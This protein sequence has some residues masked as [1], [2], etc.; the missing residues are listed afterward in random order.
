MPLADSEKRVDVVFHHYLLFHEFKCC[1]KNADCYNKNNNTN[2]TCESLCNTYFSVCFK[3]N[4]I[5]S[6][7]CYK[8]T[9]PIDVNATLIPFTTPNIVQ[10]MINNESIT[11]EVTLLRF[12]YKI[13]LY[14]CSITFVLECFADYRS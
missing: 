8:T 4:T 1:C 10:F 6:R 2:I 7:D 13:Y 3:E 9:R 12:M 5:S 14:V 11:F